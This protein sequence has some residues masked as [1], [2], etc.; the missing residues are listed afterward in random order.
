M[1]VK[2]TEGAGVIVV[3]YS[4]FLMLGILNM[5]LAMYDRHKKNKEAE[6]E[7][8]KKKSEEAKG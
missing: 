7:K 8:N 5:S 2:K 6:A 4:V 3:I 1:E